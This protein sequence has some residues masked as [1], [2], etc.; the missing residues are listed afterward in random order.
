MV[1]AKSLI[2]LLEERRRPFVVE[3]TNKVDIKDTSGL[4]CTPFED[5]PF[6]I[7]SQLDGLYLSP[8]NEHFADLMCQKEPYPFKFNSD[9]N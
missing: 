6:Y 9:S 8:V 4:M 2:D 1:H 3:A 7:R 5:R